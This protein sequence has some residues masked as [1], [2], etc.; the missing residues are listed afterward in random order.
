MPK[1]F[2]YPRLLRRLS[3]LHAPM[4]VSLDPSR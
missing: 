4:N 3:D 1:R 2:T